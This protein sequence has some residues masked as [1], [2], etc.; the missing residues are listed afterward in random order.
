MTSRPVENFGD[1]IH[2]TNLWIRLFKNDSVEFLACDES[3]AYLQ[4]V[5]TGGSRI[6]FSGWEAT[7]KVVVVEL[8]GISGKTVQMEFPIGTGFTKNL[9]RWILD[10]DPK[11]VAHKDMRIY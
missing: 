8:I 1:F 9:V 4:A 5:W 7:S 6:K 2:N 3:T 11:L 10:N